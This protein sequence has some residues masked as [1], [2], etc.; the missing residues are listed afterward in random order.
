MISNASDFVI[1]CFDRPIHLDVAHRSRFA[2][3]QIL[4]PLPNAICQQK[5]KVANSE[6]A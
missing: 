3:S 1:L 6:E 2:P 5:R 4:I